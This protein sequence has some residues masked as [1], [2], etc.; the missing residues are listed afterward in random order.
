MNK[1]QRKKFA[2]I[3]AI[4]VKEIA[5]MQRRIDNLENTM[6]RL[7]RMC[8]GRDDCHSLIWF[9]DGDDIVDFAM[10][11]LYDFIEKHTKDAKDSQL[12]NA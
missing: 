12:D 10:K 8:E 4:G 7:S 3:D 1:R 9:A 11:T 6:W 2:S 5:D